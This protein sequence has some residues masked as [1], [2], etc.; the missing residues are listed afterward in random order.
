MTGFRAS[1]IEK[2]AYKLRLEPISSRIHEIRVSRIV[3]SFSNRLETTWPESTPNVSDDHT[4]E[5]VFLFWAQGEKEMP[6]TVQS[7][8]QSVKKESTTKR[9]VLLDLDHLNEWVELPAFLYTKLHDGTLSLAHFSDVLRFC[10]L[11]RYGGWWLDATVFLSAPLPLEKGLFTIKLQS[12]KDYVSGGR[13]SGFIWHMPKGYPLAVYMKQFYLAW[14]SSPGATL[15]DYFLMDY[16]IDWFYKTF[17][18]FRE[19][20]DALPPSNPDLYF[21]QSPDCEDPYDPEKW[22]RLTTRTSF[23]KTTYKR[24]HPATPGSFYAILLEPSSN[25]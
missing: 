14:L 5:M 17:K 23:F 3:A 12:A 1:F 20:I 16:C 9:V 25:A 21:F 13:W 15:P 6:A 2:V 10:L 7:C 4:D 8:L 11:E 22:L 19:H 24:R 18:P